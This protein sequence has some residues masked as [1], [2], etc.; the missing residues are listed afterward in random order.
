MIIVPQ[1]VMPSG[2]PNN[3]LAAINVLGNVLRTEI[4]HRLSK[5]PNTAVELANTIGTAQSSVH[6]HLIVLEGH[7]LVMANKS[8]EERAGPVSVTWEL[9]PDR[10]Y[11][12]ADLWVRYVSE[13]D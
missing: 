12:L 7:G 9:V 6:R 2:M 3:V 13:S 11:E 1:L 8:P 5:G 10:V 4:L